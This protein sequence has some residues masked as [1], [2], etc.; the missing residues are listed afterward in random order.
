MPLDAIYLSALSKELASVIEGGKIEKIQQPERDTVLLSIRSNYENYKL[1]IS[2]GTGRARVH[3]T[4]QSYPNPSEPPMFCMLLR[5][6]LAGARI[7]SISQPDNERMLRFELCSRDE[8]GFE[9]DKSLI[10][11][12]IGRSSNLALLDGDGRIARHSAR[13]SP[14]DS[15]GRWSFCH[16]RPERF[17]PPR[18]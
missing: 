13:Y 12:L 1:L 16:L 5:K 14:H 4:K 18:Y 9:S 3:V 2:A 8:L 6:H 10:V 15:V 17:V 11:E 7:V